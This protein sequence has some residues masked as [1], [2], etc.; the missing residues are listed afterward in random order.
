M[1]L[2]S[3]IVLMLTHSQMLRERITHQIKA[4]A[5]NGQ[6]SPRVAPVAVEEARPIS[7]TV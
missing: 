7:W 2:Y 1:A 6:W 4:N 3:L 5:V